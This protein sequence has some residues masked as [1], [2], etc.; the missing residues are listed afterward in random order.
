MAREALLTAGSQLATN[1]QIPCCVACLCDSCAC[2]ALYSIPRPLHAGFRGGRGCGKGHGFHP[3][4]PREGIS[5]RFDMAHLHRR[6]D[7]KPR[8]ATIFRDD[9]V[10]DSES[11]RTGL[12]QLRH[13]FSHYEALLE[14]PKEP[15]GRAVE[16]A[17]WHEGYGYLRSSG[18]AGAHLTGQLVFVVFG[19]FEIS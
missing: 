7:G 16:L 11:V 9:D 12:Q 5:S 10:K 14:L 4:S 3:R 13:G 19:L 1:T 6:L 15:P 8:A 18:L 2:G 17:R